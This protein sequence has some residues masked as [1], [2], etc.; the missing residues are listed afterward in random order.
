MSRTGRPGDHVF[1]L[2]R[3]QRAGGIDQPSAGLQM[4][5]APCSSI[6][7]WLVWKARQILTA[8]SRHLISGIARQR[9][10]AG[11]RR[12]DQNTIELDAK[13]QRLRSHRAPL[14]APLRGNFRQAAQVAVAGDHASRRLRAPARSCFPA[15]RT[16]RARSSRARSRAAERSTATPISCWRP[17]SGLMETAALRARRARSSPPLPGHIASSSASSIHAG[18]LSSVA[19]SGHATGLRFTLRRTALTN[20]AAESLRA[21]L[22]SST[23][24]AT[25][26]CAG[27]R[28]R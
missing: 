15:R 14:A 13:R 5:R 19:R 26:A 6:L 27:M 10:G 1:V 17:V 4:R 21:R 7:R 28:S 11:A 22:T 12:V 16:D 24:S 3:L 2:F 18:T 20:P 25:A 9:A 23:L 8:C